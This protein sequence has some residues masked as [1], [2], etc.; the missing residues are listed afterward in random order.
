MAAAVYSTAGLRASLG[1]LAV[2]VAFA[3]GGKSD[4]ALPVSV[5]QP[6]ATVTIA[7][8]TSELRVGQSVRATATVRDAQGNVLTG[9][10]IVWSSSN[11]SVATIISGGASATV[12]A[13][14]PGT[15]IIS[16]TSGGVTG[17]GNELRVASPLSAPF[18]AVQISAGGEHT[19]ARTG[20]G[21]AYCWGL[22]FEGEV[23]D[24]SGQTF[25]PVPS[26]V[27][28]GL[29]FVDISAGGFHNC[30]RTSTGASW[31]WGENREGRLGNG[32][33][34]KEVV[35][36]LVRGDL[37]FVE[38][39]A[40]NEHTCG[41]VSAG[42][43]YCWGRNTHGQLGDGTTE[44]R[45]VPTLVSGGPRFVELSSGG[46][47]TCG[48]TSSGAAYCWGFGATAPAP[49]SPVLSFTQ[50]TTGLQH[51]CALST[52]GAYCWGSNSHGQLGDGTTVDRG[53][54]V[55]VGG[56]LDFVELTGGQFV[57][58]G[59]TS[60]ESAYCWGDNRWGQLGDGTTVHRLVPTLVVGGLDFAE[61]DAGGVHTCGRTTASV[62]YCWGSNS[63]GELGDG[64]FL[65][66]H[67]PTRVVAPPTG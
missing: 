47:H 59:R 57:T 56:G 51:A 19:C 58:C 33:T 15:A 5:S 41:R 65:E 6:V 67:V 24:G 62:V 11:P 46:E 2:L 21:V 18:I 34:G 12:A 42:A 40:G 28:G 9:R 43:T 23:G 20:T 49:V 52:S 39:S 31:C 10:P 53:A 55:L 13:V 3:C 66:R 17:R 44:H 30:G 25:R 45:P 38:L 50:L 26:L 35:P 48:R 29:T 64:T 54:P 27:F 16:A 1:V 8:D 22:N 4:D 14:A 61:L 7:L 63:E 37:S 32:L 60:T 36:S